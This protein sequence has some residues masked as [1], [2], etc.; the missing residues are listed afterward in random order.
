MVKNF[1]KFFVGI[2]ISLVLICWMVINL[3]WKEIQYTLYS[4][5]YWY[6]IPCTCVYFIH[7]YIRSKRW[8]LLLKGEETQPYSK[9]GLQVYFDAIMVGNFGTYILPL[10]A[11]EFIRPFMFSRLEGSSF[12]QV[13]ATV[14]VE[15]FFDLSAVLLTFPFIALTG[16]ISKG[17]V[18]KGVWIL[19]VLAV[20]ILL[21][22]ILTVFWSESLL[23]YSKKI[24][25]KFPAFISKRA[26]FFIEE[27][28]L[29]AKQLR[30]FKV[31]LHILF[32]S[33]LVWLTT[34]LL[35][36]FYLCL[37]PELP[38]SFWLATTLGVVIALAVAAPS[39]PGFLGVYQ[40]ACILSFTFVN[41][42]EEPA[43]AFALVTHLYQYILVVLLG[44]YSLMKYN[45]KLR[46][47]AQRM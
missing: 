5:R 20:C 7:F 23:F 32:F 44:M 27:L 19:S 39:A 13:F 47:V 9:K 3:E 10:R 18:I 15:R 24:L 45:L 42:K 38:K 16:D 33:F 11:G 29:G 37:F 36:Y 12:P 26:M 21:F 22:L 25:T 17:W 8:Q 28:F 34:Y 14:V 1:L 4:L 46:D 43:F 30:N 6:L 40:A 41:V 2:G 31:L 35:M